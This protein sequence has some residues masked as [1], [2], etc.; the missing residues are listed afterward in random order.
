MMY[1]QYYGLWCKY[2]RR[3]NHQVLFETIR[4]RKEL[5]KYTWHSDITVPML[6]LVGRHFW[7]KILFGRRTA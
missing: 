6:V 3:Q 2:E 7:S 5:K 4:Y 1:I